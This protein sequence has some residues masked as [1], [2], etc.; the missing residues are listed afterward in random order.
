MARK[1]K[2]TKADY[3]HFN[4]YCNSMSD[5]ERLAFFHKAAR[6]ESAEP[7]PAE[8]ITALMKLMARQVRGQRVARSQVAGDAAAIAHFGWRAR[9]AVA[10][11]RSPDRHFEAARSILARYGLETVK[12]YGP[13]SVPDRAM[14]ARRI[15]APS[16]A[17][18]VSDLLLIA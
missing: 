10:Y 12:L 15:E 2:L 11:K 5:G 17:F 8:R 18:G 13:R 9:R 16:V 3:D 14:G 7:L 4:A 1:E 6:I